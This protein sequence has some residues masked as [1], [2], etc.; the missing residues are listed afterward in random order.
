LTYIPIRRHSIFGKNDSKNGELPRQE[1]HHPS[2]NDGGRLGDATALHRC[3]AGG[4]QRYWRLPP[5]VIRLD[6]KR[7]WNYDRPTVIEVRVMRQN[8]ETAWKYMNAFA[9][10]DH[11]EILSFLTDSVLRRTAY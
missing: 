7:D 4:G 9:K 11:P 6:D 8:M 2:Q 1:S 10:T 3:G 5:L